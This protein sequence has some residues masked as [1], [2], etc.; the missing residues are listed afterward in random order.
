MAAAL[1]KPQII[2]HL[3]K[4]VNYTLYDAKWIPC[5]AKFVA[6]GSHPRGTGAL[7]VY[8]VSSGGLELRKEV[9]N[10]RLEREVLLLYQAICWN[11]IN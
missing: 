1:E 11:K 8:E 2:V 5:S 10:C 7:Q 3:Q 6:M 9:R 4:D